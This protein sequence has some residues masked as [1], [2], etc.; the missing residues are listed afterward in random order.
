MSKLV[1]D[2]QVPN[3]YEKQAVTGIIRAICQQVN[4]LSEGAI[5]ARYQAQTANPTTNASVSYAQGDI[6]WNSKPTEL[7]SVAPGLSAKYVLAGWECVGSGTGSGATFKE[8]RWLT[9]N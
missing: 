4:S 2:F 7:S 9:G 8:I 1:L 6:V 3:Q 5:T